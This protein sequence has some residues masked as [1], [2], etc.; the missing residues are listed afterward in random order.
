[1]DDLLTKAYYFVISLPFVIAAWIS[2]KIL[3]NDRR[4]TVLEELVRS[5]NREFE[6]RDKQRAEDRELMKEMRADL[7]TIR[8][9]I[10]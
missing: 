5:I 3:D 10:N 1:M 7:K 6:T 8:E 9:K 4:I 2:K